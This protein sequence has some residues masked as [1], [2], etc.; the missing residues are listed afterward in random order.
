VDRDVCLCVCISLLSAAG[1]R[2]LFGGNSTDAH[3][4]ALLAWLRFGLARQAHAADARQQ[5]GEPTGGH[6][7]AAPAVDA[8]Q[9]EGFLA[10][11]LRARRVAVRLVPFERTDVRLERGTTSAAPARACVRPLY[12]H[13]GPASLRARHMLPMCAPTTRHERE[14]YQRYLQSDGDPRAP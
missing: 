7:P 4:T 14:L 3:V 6:R 5:S 10:S 9:S 2:V 12:Y 13:C 11:L 1:A 8:L